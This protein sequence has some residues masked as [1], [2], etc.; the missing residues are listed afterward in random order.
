[1]VRRLWPPQHPPTPAISLHDAVALSGRFPLLAGVDLEVPPGETVLLEGAERSG[2]DESSAGLCRA[3]PARLGAGE[4]VRARSGS[5]GARRYAGEPASSPTTCHLY[6]DLTVREN[7]RFAVRAAGAAAER[8]DPACERLGLTGRLLRTRAAEAL[9]GP[10]PA[11]GDRGA[12]R[13]STRALAPRRA[14]RRARPL[15]PGDPR[16]VGRRSDPGRSH[17]GRSPRTSR[18][19]SSRSRPAPITLSGGRV[20]GERGLVRRRRRRPSAAGRDHGGLEGS[21]GPCGVTVSSSPG[22]TCGSR[23]ARVSRSPRWSPS[24]SSR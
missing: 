6:D 9:G 24:A 23:R 21:G 15:R 5:T 18:A 10:A 12:G 20:V 13:A 14:A 3:G 2:Q 1:M 16:R 8:V 11:G 19:R 7:V 4:G 22:R 17:R